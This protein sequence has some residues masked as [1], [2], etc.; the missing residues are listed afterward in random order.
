MSTAVLGLVQDDSG[1][2]AAQ[3][4]NCRA[5]GAR[6]RSGAR[7]DDDDGT[8]V[9][10]ELGSGTRQSARIEL[11]SEKRSGFAHVRAA[12]DEALGWPSG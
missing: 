11:A 5:W 6:W 12:A 7:H 10:G 2:Q 1:V 9:S 8:R 4:G 3:V